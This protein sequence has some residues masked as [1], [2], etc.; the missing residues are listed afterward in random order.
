MTERAVR[1]AWRRLADAG[2]PSLAGHR[3]PTN[4]PH[5]T[6]ASADALPAGVRARLLGALAEALPVPLRLDGFVRFSGR[7]RVLAWAVRPDDA[8]LRLHGAVWRILREA[9]ESGWPNPLLDP[10]RWAPPRHPRPGTGRLLGRAGRRGVVLLGRHAGGCRDRGVDGRPQLRL[11]HA[12]GGGP[13]VLGRAHRAGH[14]GPGPIDTPPSTA[15]VFFVM[16][17]RLLV[18]CG[19]VV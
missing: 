10:A 8:L 3:H 18:V 7:V 19:R 4:R 5:L 2:L 9:P 12:H 14:R 16:V 15:T 6:L 13:G 17:Y 11:G 1:E